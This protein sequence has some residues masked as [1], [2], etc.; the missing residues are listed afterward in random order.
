LLLSDKSLFID[1][2]PETFENL[3]FTVTPAK[4][5][6]QKVVKRLDTGFRRYDDLPSFGRFSK[7]STRFSAGKD[8]KAALACQGDFITACFFAMEAIQGREAY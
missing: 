8:T 3:L 7:V 2:E 4:A 5:G 6:V 1:T